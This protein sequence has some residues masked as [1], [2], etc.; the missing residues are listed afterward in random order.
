MK[1]ALLVMVLVIPLILAGCGVVVSAKYSELLDKTAV[2]SA[3]TARRAE[4]GELTSEEMVAALKRQAETWQRFRDA[5]DGK[6][7]AP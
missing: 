1:R 3:E 7:G 4:A 6:E 2:L 5:R